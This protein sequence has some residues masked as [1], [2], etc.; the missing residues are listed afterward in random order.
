MTFETFK[1]SISKI[2]NFDLLG[3]DAHVKMSPLFRREELKRLDFST[4][5]GKNAGVLVLFYPDK[6]NQT[7]LV[8]IL[9]KTYKGVHSAQVGFPGGKEENEDDSL[10]DT[11]LREA[12]EEVGVLPSAVEIIKPL[13]KIYIPP[14]NFW[15]YP[16]LGITDH[17][18]NFV[19][20]ETEVEK[21]LEID[22]DNFLDSKS[23]IEKTLSTSYAENVK[24]PAFFLNEYVVWGATAMMLSEVKIFL[25]RALKT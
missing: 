18:P 17:T 21:I 9:R 10:L 13:S 6:Q 23:L 8:L 16:F 25:E 14:S 3:E 11:A 20:Q 12:Y 19:R 4:K 15:V 24:V 1:K 2:K 7:K 22:V 5:K